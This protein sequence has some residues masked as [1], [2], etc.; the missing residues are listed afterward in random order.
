MR[1]SY[2]RTLKCLLPTGW[3]R[4]TEPRRF[5]PAASLEEEAVFEVC[6]L[7]LEVHGGMGYMRECPIEKY[8][9]DVISFLHGAGNNHIYRIKG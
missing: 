3:E 8:L 1:P 4:K 9:R 7:G 5:G 6:R 2:S